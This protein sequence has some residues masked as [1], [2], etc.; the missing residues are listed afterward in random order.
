MKYLFGSQNDKL[1]C[2]PEITATSVAVSPGDIDQLQFALNLEHTEAAFFLYGALGYVAD[3]I[4]PT[5]AMGGP[6]PLG[7]MKANLDDV[8]RQIIEEFG[9]QEVGHLRFSN[10]ISYK[11]NSL[12]LLTITWCELLTKINI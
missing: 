12:D 5:L 6:P 1:S 4:D 2:V 8:T 10:Y 3:N 11:S 7:A 9:Y